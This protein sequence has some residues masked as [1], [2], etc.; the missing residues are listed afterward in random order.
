MAQPIRRMSLFLAVMLLLSGC[1]N[2]VRDGSEE[3]DDEQE[4]DGESDLP[5]GRLVF[6]GDAVVE[7][8]SGDERLDTRMTVSVTDTAGESLPLVPADDLGLAGIG[9]VLPVY[10]SG[11]AL[12][13]FRLNVIAEAWYGGAWVAVLDLYDSLQTPASAEDRVRTEFQGAFHP[14]GE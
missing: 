12:E 4:V 6:T 7:L 13:A 11:P 8:T 5:D 9:G 14:T 1:R 2:I 3:V 10:G